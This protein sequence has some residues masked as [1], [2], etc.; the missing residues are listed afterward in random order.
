MLK[1]VPARQIAMT[2]GHVALLILL[3]E[4][5]LDV[6]TYVKKILE[7]INSIH[8]DDGHLPSMKIVVDGLLEI[9]SNTESFLLGEHLLLGKALCLNNNYYILQLPKLLDLWLIKYLS[10]NSYAEQER[11]LVCINGTLVKISNIIFREGNNLQ[12]LFA[13]IYKYILPYVQQMFAN[14]NVDGGIVSELAANLCLYSQYCL[15]KTLNKF[16]ILFKGFVD[17]SCAN[18]MSVLRVI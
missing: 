7:Q 6:T 3:T 1:L 8:L 18:I 13:L 2:R 14:K 10:A 17:T 15:P 4:R 5:K 16:D 9:F 11:V 12:T